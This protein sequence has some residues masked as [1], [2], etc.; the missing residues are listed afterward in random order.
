MATGKGGDEGLFWVGEVGVAKV[1]GSGGAGDGLPVAKVELV[2]AG[3]FFVSERGI[4]AR[5]GEM[6]CVL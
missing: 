5:P 4:V 3:V 2:V 6:C 1:F